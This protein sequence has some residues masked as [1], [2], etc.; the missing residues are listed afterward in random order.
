M[1]GTDH[2]MVRILRCCKVSLAMA[3]VDGW[4]VTE[5]TESP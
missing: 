1:M 3:G 5:G 4:F 2:I